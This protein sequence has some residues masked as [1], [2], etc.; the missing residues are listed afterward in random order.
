MRLHF[1]FAVYP[2][3]EM[4]R[5]PLEKSEKACLL[6]SSFTLP[7]HPG[8][9]TSPDL[10]PGREERKVGR[11][12]FPAPLSLALMKPASWRPLACGYRASLTSLLTRR[13]GFPQLVL[14]SHISH[15]L[16]FLE[17]LALVSCEGSGPPRWPW[18]GG[19]LRD[20]VV[21]G[22]TR[23]AWSSGESCP[24]LASP[25]SPLGEP[26][27]ERTCTGEQSAPKDF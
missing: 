24:G 22:A 25:G 5:L 14:I 2:A 18:G 7:A 26:S 16:L 6:N 21:L 15:E 10:P 3:T 13:D 23:G 19:W 27:R 1:L 8:G 4:I 12:P 11:L 17:L 9:I 20:K